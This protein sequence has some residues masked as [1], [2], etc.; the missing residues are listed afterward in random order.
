MN[1]P[2]VTPRAH[3]LHAPLRMHIIRSFDVNR[4]QE[5]TMESVEELKGGVIGGV[6]LEGCLRVG[7]VVEVRPGLIEK[8]GRKCFPI[9]SQVLS[10]KAG[11]QKLD[12][13]YPGANVG[14]ELTVDPVLTKQDA[15]Q[16][17]VVLAGGLQ[18][19][20]L[21]FA[22]FVMT[23]VLLGGGPWK[24]NENVRINIG[25]SKRQGKIVQSKARLVGFEGSEHNAVIVKLDIPLSAPIGA[26]VAVTRQVHKAWEF[27]AAGVIRAVRKA[28]LDSWDKH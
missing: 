14:L 20:P 3:Q 9:K 7:D 26:K 21:V 11:T 4:P 28:K 15:M 12:V 16:G 23:Y 10:I 17:H 22:N 27:C 8:E 19:E 2:A 18:R 24:P 25:A 6:V 13:A 1:F 5:I